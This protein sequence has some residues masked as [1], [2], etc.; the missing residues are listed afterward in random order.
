M[1]EINQG[2]ISPAG[3][4]SQKKCPQCG[5]WTVWQLRADDVCGHCG[6]PLSVHIREKEE[7]AQK[8]Q[9]APSGLFPILDTDG[10]AMV[11]GKRSLNLAHVVFTAVVGSVIWFITVVVA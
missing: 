8:I 4:A 5:R 9:N 1:M 11:W 7:R 6:E 2:P 10:P 3:S